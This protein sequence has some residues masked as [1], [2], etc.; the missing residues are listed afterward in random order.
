MAS[1]ATPWDTATTSANIETNEIDMEQFKDA[2][3]AVMDRLR[4]VKV[5][6]LMTF[7]L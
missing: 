5:D 1:H 7:S 2:E 4:T 3:A 6:S